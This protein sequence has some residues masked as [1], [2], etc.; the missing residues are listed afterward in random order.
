MYTY[1]DNYNYS[2]IMLADDLLEPYFQ[3]YNIIIQ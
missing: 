1:I 3:F 2:T